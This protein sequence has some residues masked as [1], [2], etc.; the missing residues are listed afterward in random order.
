MQNQSSS[1]E[2][3]LQPHNVSRGTVYCGDYCHVALLHLLKY[4]TLKCLNTVFNV[5][6]REIK[7]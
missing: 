5:F 6:L 7:V 3:L 4:K 1:L 2:M